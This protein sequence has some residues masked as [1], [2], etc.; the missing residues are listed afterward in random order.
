[1]SHSLSHSHTMYLA[2]VPF[3]LSKYQGGERMRG[4]GGGEGGGESGAPRVASE[5]SGREGERGREWRADGGTGTEWRAVWR[6]ESGKGGMGGER[7]GQSVGRM[8]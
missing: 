1:M 5:V 8:S 7:E 3:N 4:V 6:A 2:P